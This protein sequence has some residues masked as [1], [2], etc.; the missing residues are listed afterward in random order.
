MSSTSLTAIKRRMRGIN[1]LSKATKAMELTAS[2]QISA[3]I[4]KTKCSEE[5]Y[6]NTI[7]QTPS[8]NFL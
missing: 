3:A 1:S 6:W 7:T 5:L 4:D 8:A 2:A